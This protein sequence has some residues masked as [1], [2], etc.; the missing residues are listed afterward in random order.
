MSPSVGWGGVR[1]L[2]YT[3]TGSGEPLVL[4]HGLGSHRGA[5][6]AVV[7]L[8][9]AEF[10][11]LAV[12]L[13]GF[14]GSPPLPA[15][16]EPTPGALAAAVAGLLD[17]LAVDR[18]HLAGSS[19]GGW[20]A[21]ELARLRP[22][23]SVALLSPAGLWP[24]GTPR[25]TRASLRATRWLCEHLE[26]PLHAVVRFG[27]ARSVVLAQI[28]GRPARLTPTQ[29]RDAISRMAHCP[30][31]P[32]TERA[33]AHQH[34]RSAGPV[35]ASVTVAFGSR[36]RL[37]LAGRSRHVEQLPAGTRVAALPGCGHLPM[38]DDPAAVAALL[39]TA[40]GRAGSTME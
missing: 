39:A 13:P 2:A 34:Y 31:F 33:M 17:E 32:P 3:R 18:P 22:V 15:G 14:G 11:V 8:L 20:V 1:V 28:Y 24:A 36:D 40:A 7:P 37:L 10:D 29:A 6:E 23:A 26:R 9:A 4:L 25:Y 16:V 12:D 5:W 19:L 38:S 30:G 21:L 27:V 35:G